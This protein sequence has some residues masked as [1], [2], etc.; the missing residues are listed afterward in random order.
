[1]KNFGYFAIVGSSIILSSCQLPSGLVAGNSAVTI[2]PDPSPTVGYP[3]G[4]PSPTPTPS[5]S[6]PV[7]CDPLGPSNGT[8]TAQNGLISHLYY[9]PA[10]GATYGD[11]ESYIQN[12][13]EAPADIFF[14]QLNVPTR[15][16]SEGFSTQNGTVLID[17]ETGNTLYEWFALHFESQIKLGSLDSPGRYQFAVLS[18]D[19]AIMWLNQ[20]SSP[21]TPFIN[22]DGETPSR[23]ACA[24]TGINFDANTLIPMKLDYFQGPRYNIALMLLWREIP[25]VAAGATDDPANLYDVACGQAGNDTYF[26]WENPPDVPTPLW[27]G[28]LARGWKVL[29][30]DNYVLP[31]TQGV[32][33]NP[34]ASPTPSPTASGPVVCGID[35]S[36]TAGTSSSGLVGT[37]KYLPSSSY[38][39]DANSTAAGVC[40]YGNPTA[41]GCPD[42]LN[43]DYAYMDSNGTSSPATIYFSDMNVIPQNFTLGFPTST[44]GTLTDNSGNVLTSYFS[45]DIQGQIQLAA[46][47]TAGWYQFSTLSDDGSILSLDTTGTGVVQPVVRNDYWHGAIMQCAAQAV[48]MTPGQPIKMELQYFQGAPTSIAMMIMWRQVSSQNPPAN[49]YCGAN[50]IPLDSNG[51]PELNSAQTCSGI[52]CANSGGPA[53]YNIG[54]SSSTPTALFSD[55]ESSGGTGAGAWQPLTSANYLLP[56]NSQPNPCVTPTPSP[57]PSAT[58]CSGPLCGG[59]GLG[60]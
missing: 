10:G 2:V 33:T 60:V 45:L 29:S 58:Q 18:D 31:G 27:I 17:P 43:L 37:L 3:P 26:L 59:G 53:Y 19:G 57:S 32:A 34:C 40:N 56:A 14:N 54:T 6:V 44:G 52:G 24:S 12:D 48:Y 39:F 38:S 9:T 46:G 16:F 30:P 25:E 50:S 15:S 7:V 28:M 49:T 13:P 5:S 36:T 1:M 55:M 41:A 51:N 8:G 42:G 20:G 11:V 47:Q 4:F 35:G 21:E 23:L 22:N